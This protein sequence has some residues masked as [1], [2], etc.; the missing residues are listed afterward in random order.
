MAP[1]CDDGPGKENIQ[2]LSGA[3]GV[4][5][6]ASL[7]HRELVVDIRDR[8]RH[9]SLKFPLLI[10]MTLTL[11]LASY[12]WLVRFTFI[13]RALNGKRHVR[14]SPQVAAR[15]PALRATDPSS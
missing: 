5:F 10:A 13:G 2:T 1:A 12:H 8:R 7:R 9:W 11:L 6:R 3:R 14:H 15:L 4:T